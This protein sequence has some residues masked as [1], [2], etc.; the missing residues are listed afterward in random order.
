M[1]VGV[2]GGLLRY[3]LWTAVA[4]KTSVLWLS[5]KTVRSRV[6]VSRKQLIALATAA[7]DLICRPEK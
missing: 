4:N 5:Y 2:E 1:A 7:I 6:G 3:S